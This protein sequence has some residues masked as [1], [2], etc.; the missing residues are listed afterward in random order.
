MRA[1]LLAIFLVL[2]TSAASVCAQTDTMQLVQRKDRTLRG[3]YSVEATITGAIQATRYED[4][5][6]VFSRVNVF[7]G[8]TFSGRL[9]WHP[10]HLLSVG[11]YSGFVTFSRE[12]ITSTDTA[13]RVQNL[14]LDLT[15]IPAQMVVAMA[16]GHFQFGLGLGVYFLTS[17]IRVNDNEQFESSSYEYG[18]S[19]WLAYD[20][21]ITDAIALGPEIGAHAL[22]SMGVASGM[23]GLRLKID[24]LTY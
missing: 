18:V 1:I 13:G 7:P 15:G 17:H 6:T 8:S 3:L 22:S 5:P 11:V 4:K 23:I 9:M 16:P 2:S 20:F 10:D 21:Q 19:S 14:T 12:N 24:L